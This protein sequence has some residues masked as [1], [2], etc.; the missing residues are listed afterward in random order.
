MFTSY[1]KSFREQASYITSLGSS[2]LALTF[3]WLAI[4]V[5]LAFTHYITLVML[6]VRIIRTFVVLHLIESGAEGFDL[7]DK[8]EMDSS[9]PMI[10]V[11][12][13]LASFCGWRVNLLI[14]TPLSILTTY[15]A[16]YKSYSVIDDENN[17]SCY[18]VPDSYAYKMS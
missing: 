6:S 2:V 8:K 18:L 4:K 13:L 17:M 14:S 16:T 3:L 5:N 12:A 1:N 15:V 11:P 9:I 7:I 10:A